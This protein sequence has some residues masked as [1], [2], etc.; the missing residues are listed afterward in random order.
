[1]GRVRWRDFSE[2][3]RKF[4]SHKIG[5]NQSILK[6]TNPEYSLE[7]LTLKL[8]SFDY[9][10]RRTDS[11]EKTPRLGKIEGRRRRD[12]EDEMVGWHH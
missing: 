4:L 8:Q 12:A 9:L 3:S 11:L 6:E 10:I 5:S 1:M 7:V 2:P